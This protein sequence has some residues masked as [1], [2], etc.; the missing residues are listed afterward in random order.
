MPN[1]TAA[2]VNTRWFQDQLADRRLS[3]RKLAKMMNLDPSAVSLMLRGLRVISADEAAD[4]ARILGLPL[5]DVLSQIGVDLPRETGVDM[6]QIVG[7]V[8][9]NNRIHPQTQAGPTAAPKPPGAV[10]GTVAVRHMTDGYRDG[11]LV[12]FC[13]IDYVMPEAMGRLSVVEYAKT[14]TTALRVLKHGYE[15]GLYR[16]FDPS[17]G[18]PETARI[19]SA[20]VVTW[21]KQ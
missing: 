10:D 2:A 8:D 7:W 17:G 4:M 5:P 14:G 18:E 3:Q 16:L 6:V 19:T 9:D 20:S 13:P 11:W 21:I 1:S 12:Y 15:P